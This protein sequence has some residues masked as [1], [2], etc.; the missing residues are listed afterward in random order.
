[1]QDLISY[2]KNVFSQFGEDGVI[3]KVFRILKSDKEKWCVEF[4]AWDGISYSN[5]HSLIKNKGWNGVLIEVNKTRFNE[6]LNTYLNSKKVVCLNKFVG[7]KGNNRLDKILANTKIP[8]EFDLLSIDIDGNDFYIWEGLK[9]YKPKVVLIEFNPTIPH[10]IEFVQ[11]K[12]FGVFQGSSLLSLVKLA[13]SKRYELIATTDANAIFVR[14]KYY[15]L[16]KIKDNRPEVLHNNEK[17]LTKMFQLFDGTIVISGCQRLLWHGVN[18]AQDEMQVLPKV[19]RRFPSW[20]N[21]LL[22]KL[23]KRDLKALFSLLSLALKNL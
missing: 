7:F 1:M 5:T 9:R 13:K 18:F 6:L 14:R 2:K 21:I 15:K 10:D 3:D 4:G 12:D 20:F 19:L 22:V 8:E 17:Y 23:V 11:S 16:F